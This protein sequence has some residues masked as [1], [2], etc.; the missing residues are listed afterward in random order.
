MCHGAAPKLSPEGRIAHRPGNLALG[1]GL[2]STLEELA[3][4]LYGA[5]PLLKYCPGLEDLGYILAHRVCPHS[6]HLTYSSPLAC[7]KHAR[8]Q[9]LS[10]GH[11]EK[12]FGS[13]TVHVM[14]KLQKVQVCIRTVM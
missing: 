13:S 10:G 5:M 9:C 12:L 7:C 11:M 8:C 1:V 14:Q 3:G 6:L 2:D 4:Q